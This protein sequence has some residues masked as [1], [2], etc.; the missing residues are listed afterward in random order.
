MATNFLTK[1]FGSRNDRLIK[2]FRKTVDR[3][4]ALEPQIAALSDDEMRARIKELK[5]EVAAG[6][7]LDAAMDETF[8]IVREAAICSTEPRQP[9][10]AVARRSKRSWKAYVLTWSFWRSTRT[11]CASTSTRANLGRCR[12]AFSPHRAFAPPSVA[13]SSPPL[14]V[15]DST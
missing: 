14:I 9:Q 6:K 1:L 4:N 12:R 7:T 13:Y 2:Q 15:P 3:I 11:T 10:R 5:A 8:A